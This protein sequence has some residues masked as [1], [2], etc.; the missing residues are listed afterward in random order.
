MATIQERYDT[1][2]A[3]VQRAVTVTKLSAL[4]P[5]LLL[6]PDPANIAANELDKLR[7]R[8]A[9]ATND[10]ERAVVARDAE[11]LADRIEE[12]LPGAPQDWKRT[13]LYPGEVPHST[14][15]LSFLSELKREIADDW[16][17][18]DTLETEK[19]RSSLVP[20]VLIGGTLVL[21]LLGL[22][23]AAGRREGGDDAAELND[24]LERVANYS[25]EG[26][27]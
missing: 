10:L 1:A 20:L 27:V 8:W 19:N 24:E 3:Y 13:N 18:V 15:A 7:V 4:N 12:N 5:I 2:T 6:R 23:G 26:A 11:L 16:M 9:R 14:P 22:D 21:A 25:E 17:S